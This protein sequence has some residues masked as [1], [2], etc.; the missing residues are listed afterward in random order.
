MFWPFKK[1]EKPRAS[2]PEYWELLLPRASYLA[3]KSALGPQGWSWEELERICRETAERHKHEED[4]GNM[5]ADLD[6]QFA[7]S[8]VWPRSAA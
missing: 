3:T 7:I 4:I 2:I 5:I 6:S 1:R 8:P